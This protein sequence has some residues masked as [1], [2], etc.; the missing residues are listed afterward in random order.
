MRQADQ[1]PR[2]YGGTVDFDI[3]GDTWSEQ[4]VTRAKFCCFK[5]WPLPG[6]HVALA[7][8]LLPA[9]CASACAL[10]ASCSLLFAL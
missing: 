1:L 8:V 10:P 2:D 6:P 9:L 3:L 4:A 5:L 7:T